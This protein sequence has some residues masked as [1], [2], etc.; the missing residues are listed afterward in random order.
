MNVYVDVIG[1]GMMMMR[2][3][4]VKW[5]SWTMLT[6]PEARWHLGLVLVVTVRRDSLRISRHCAYYG[7]SVKWVRESVGKGENERLAL[8][9]L[10][11]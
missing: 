6:A 8:V 5:V 2:M 9:C 10:M 7:W 11:H 1:C 4:I 3:E